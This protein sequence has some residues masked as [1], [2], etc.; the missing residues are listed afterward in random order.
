MNC[1][2]CNTINDDDAVFCANCGCT[3]NALAEAP[4]KTWK[5]YWYALLLVP[6]LLAAAGMGYYKFMLPNGIAAV[7]NGEEIAMA[8]LDAVMRSARDGRDVG[9]SGSV[10][11][12]VI[13]LASGR[14]LRSRGVARGTSR[15]GTWLRLAR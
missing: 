5:S 9:V 4:R 8:E 13:S 6:V 3:L 1:G 14:G 12:E 10:A 15:S 2:K 7:V 11:G